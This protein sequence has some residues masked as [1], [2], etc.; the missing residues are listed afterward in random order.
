MREEKAQ[1]FLSEKCSVFTYTHGFSDK[2]KHVV[3]FGQALLLLH[4]ILFPEG[5]DLLW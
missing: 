5:C 4:R 3:F 1:L 2:V